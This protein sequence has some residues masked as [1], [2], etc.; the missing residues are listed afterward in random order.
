MLAANSKSSYRIWALLVIV[1]AVGLVLGVLT[2][3]F[4]PDIVFLAILILFTSVLVFKKPMLGIIGSIILT[5]TVLDGTSNPRVFLGFGHIYLTDIILFTLFWLIGWK[6]LTRLE[7][8]FVR[9]PL[10]VPL[11]LFVAITI[12][13]TI[14][15]IMKGHV[16][17]QENLGAIRDVLNLLIFFT[18]TK[19]YQNKQTNKNIGENNYCLCMYCR[20]G[21][22]CSI[23]NGNNFTVFAWTS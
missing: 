15:A 1:V 9:T 16:T 22:G 12:T 11:I 10:D 6:L 2:S 23:H 19:S 4:S 7:E 18:V 21:Y 17:I 13:S 20:N 3:A 14:I 8:K 5:S